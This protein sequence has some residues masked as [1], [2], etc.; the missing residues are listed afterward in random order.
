MTTHIA[1][2]DILSGRLISSSALLQVFRNKAAVGTIIMKLSKFC[3]HMWQSSVLVTQY[4]PLFL[5][6]II[7]STALSSRLMLTRPDNTESQVLATAL[8][9]CALGWMG[10]VSH[11]T[12]S[13]LL[14]PLWQSQEEQQ[15][16]LDLWLI[17]E[18]S[19][20]LCVYI[21][22]LKSDWWE[23]L[24]W[25]GAP[26]PSVGCSPGCSLST[27]L[28]CHPHRQRE[29]SAEG[30]LQ[31]RN[32][33]CRFSMKDL[34][35][36]HTYQIRLSQLLFLLKAS[37]SW[38]SPHRHS[39][40]LFFWKILPLQLPA[41][42][43]GEVQVYPLTVCCHKSWRDLLTVREWQISPSFYLVYA[44]KYLVIISYLARI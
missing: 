26:F 30:L 20:T 37:E 28:C 41:A 18:I 22:I 16:P 12:V 32:W 9:G 38:S 33:N 2:G 1:A 31:G 23:R 34:P 11:W 5:H 19:L 3:A 24:G 15:K 10:V 27:G 44:Q 25:E 7:S 42:R 8:D 17:F 29:F 39:A 6:W 4:L 13:Q 35:H 40:L 43:R 14:D 36:P 21:S